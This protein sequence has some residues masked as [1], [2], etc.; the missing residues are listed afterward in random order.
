MVLLHYHAIVPQGL[1]RGDGGLWH[2]HTG[3]FGRCAIAPQ[4]VTR[5]RSG[6]SGSC[7]TSVPRF[8]MACIRPHVGLFRNTLGPLSVQ[9][10]ALLVSCCWLVG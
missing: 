7:G 10:R 6:G 5:G 4:A 8:A 3:H 1:F 2:R 9:P